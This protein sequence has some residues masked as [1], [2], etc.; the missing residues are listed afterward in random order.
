MPARPRTARAAAVAVQ[1]PVGLFAR[2]RAQADKQRTPLEPYVINDVD[3]PILIE[4][5]ATTEQQIGLAELFDNTGDFMLKDARR[6]LELICGESFPAVWELMRREHI[7]VLVGFIQELGL[8][9]G[10]LVSA[11]EDEVPGG[12]AAS[13]T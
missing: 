8:Y 2:L 9:F 3:P 12:S 11:A 6:V 1:P 5:P 13:S 10:G 7:S 4:Q